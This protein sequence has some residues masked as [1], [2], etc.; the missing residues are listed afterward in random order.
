MNGRSRFLCDLCEDQL[1]EDQ[2]KIEQELG[3]RLLY[4]T[5]R[6]HGM[7]DELCLEYARFHPHRVMDVVFFEA[8]PRFEECH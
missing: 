5:A 7:E 4:F 1:R 6:C 2:V 3:T 8:R